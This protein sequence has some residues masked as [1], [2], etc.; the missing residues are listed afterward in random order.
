LWG[1]ALRDMLKKRLPPEGKQR[2]V[3][4]AHAS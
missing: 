1:K 3:A 4:A 2:F